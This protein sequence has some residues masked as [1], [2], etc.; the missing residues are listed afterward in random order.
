MFKV[1]KKVTL[2]RK[3]PFIILD[4]ADLNILNKVDYFETFWLVALFIILKE[5]ECSVQFCWTGKIFF[6]LFNQSLK[7]Y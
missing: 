1:R 5:I 4:I 7:I 2:N 3:K 6:L